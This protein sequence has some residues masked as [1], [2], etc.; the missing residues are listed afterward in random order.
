[1]EEFYAAAR[2]ADYLIYNSTI[3]GEL[4]S[5]EELFGKSELLENFKAVRDG[6]G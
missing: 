1:M 6:N 3:D 2:E 4:S 5:V